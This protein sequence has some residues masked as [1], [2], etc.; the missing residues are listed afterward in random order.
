MIRRIG[1]NQL[2]DI[3]VDHAMYREE[4]KSGIV[5]LTPEQVVEAASHGWKEIQSHPA[6]VEHGLR[7]VQR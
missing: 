6:D 7:R 2:G 3:V 1:F 5:L 4:I